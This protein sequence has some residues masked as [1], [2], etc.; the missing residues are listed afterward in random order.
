MVHTAKRWNV[1]PKPSFS[2]T[3]TDEIQ[4]LVSERLHVAHEFRVLG[5]KGRDIGDVSTGDDKQ[6]GARCGAS[7]G[8]A[9]EGR[10][11]EDYVES[12]WRDGAEDAIG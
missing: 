7:I 8:K 1:K 5:C 6:V 12:V 9:D 4:S 10:C 2:R 3:F 11:F